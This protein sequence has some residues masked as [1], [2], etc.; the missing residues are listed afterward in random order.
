MLCSI[1]TSP[2]GRKEMY[3]GKLELSWY[4]PEFYQVPESIIDEVRNCPTEEVQK[5]LQKVVS[6]CD[7][8]L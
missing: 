8:I 7:K 1:I 2:T 4:K 6:T 5:I 3:Y